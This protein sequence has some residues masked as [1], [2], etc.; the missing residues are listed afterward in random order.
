MEA[1]YN[2]ENLLEGAS[3]DRKALERQFERIMRDHGP[4]VLRLISVYANDAASREDLR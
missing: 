1:E 3:V 4:S 2:A